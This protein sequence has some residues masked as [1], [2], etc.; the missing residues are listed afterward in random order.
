MPPAPG[1]QPARAVPIAGARAKVVVALSLAL[2][3]LQV[4]T[5]P[6]KHLAAFAAEPAAL[7]DAQLAAV[8]D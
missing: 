8:F 1:G 6:R 2:R 3:R 4:L 7:L 5:A